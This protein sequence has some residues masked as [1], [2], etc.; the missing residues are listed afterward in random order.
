MMGIRREG[1]KEEGNEGRKEGQEGDV[2]EGECALVVVEGT[3]S[4]CCWIDPQDKHVLV[5]CGKFIM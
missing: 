2:R 4:R 5:G 1:G 3:A